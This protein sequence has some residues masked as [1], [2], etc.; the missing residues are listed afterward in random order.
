M[1]GPLHVYYG[2]EI[3][4]YYFGPS[5]PFNQRRVEFAVDLMRECGLFDSND[6][7]CRPIP[8]ASLEDA[9]LFHTPEY[10]RF[11]EHASRRGTGYLDQGDTPAFPGC[12]DAS[13]WLVG[14]ALEAL[15]AVL[16]GQGHAF[17]PG[18]GT[19]HGYRDHASGFCI[20]DDGAVALAAA[21]ERYEV[22]KALYLDI[23]VHHGDGVFYGFLDDA[24]LLD[25]DFHQ[26]GRTLFPGKGFVHEIG[27]GE[28]TGVKLNLPFLPGAGDDSVL[29]AWQEV[30]VPAIRVFQPELIVMQC[31]ADA[32]SG[33]P[34]ASLEWSLNPYLEI[35]ASVHALA[36]ELCDGRLLLL[37]G[38]GYN[39][40][41][42]CM[43]WPAIAHT[44]GEVPLPPGVPDGWR[45]RFEA[46]YGMPAPRRFSEPPTT[47]T[48]A[49]QATVRCAEELRRRSHLLA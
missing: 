11:L 42:V 46:H 6:N 13:L 10:L 16:T 2:P 28:A 15:D 24:W 17:S 23:D 33:D 38:G 27:E 43:V 21:H 1:S 8:Q 26:D 18:G 37:G 12:L 3:Q 9:L 22:R 32:H 45:Q 40:A 36:H 29:L 47:S 19:H 48:R 49:L 20:L 31:G 14:S 5:H 39:A 35:A 30:A 4:Q 25:I 44:V 34:L 41:N 7:T